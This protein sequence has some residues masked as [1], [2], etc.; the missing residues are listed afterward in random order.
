ML[1]MGFRDQKR[2]PY[3]LGYKERTCFIRNSV[4]QQQVPLL[5]VEMILKVLVSDE[6]EVWMTSLVE[7]QTAGYFMG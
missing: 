4:L 1:F 3:M 2:L 7:M 5:K 6:K